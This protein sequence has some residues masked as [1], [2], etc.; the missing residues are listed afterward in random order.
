MY[1][2]VTIRS[3]LINH[4]ERDFRQAQGILELSGTGKNHTELFSS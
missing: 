4:S 3:F 1:Q 2:L